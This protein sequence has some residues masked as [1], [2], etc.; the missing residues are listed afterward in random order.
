MGKKSV[1]IVARTHIAFGTPRGIK[2]G[3]RDC[4]LVALRLEEKSENR[5]LYVAYCLSLSVCYLRE[6][7]IYRILR[8]PDLLPEHCRYCFLLMRFGLT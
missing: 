4:Q 8:N 5:L 2:I 1:R 7:G 3:L 6:R